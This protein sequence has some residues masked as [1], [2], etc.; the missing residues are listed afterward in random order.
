MLDYGLFCYLDVEKSGSTFIRRFLRKHVA[1]PELRGAKHRAAPFFSRRARNKLFF[2]SCRDPLS[3]YISLY[4]FGMEGKGGLH[5]R[6]SVLP[7]MSA[8]Y[9]GTPEAFERWLR[10][11]L[12]PAS[13]AKI[14]RSFGKRQAR[15]YGLMTH[16]FLRLSFR[17]W[18]LRYRLLGS[19]EQVI[20]HYRSKRIHSA[21]VRNENLA[22]DLAE[23]VRDHLE[24]YLRDPDEALS[25]LAGEAEKVNASRKS[26]RFMSALG[27][28]ELLE[29]VSEREWFFQD[30]LGY[31]PPSAPAADFQSSR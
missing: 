19:R 31:A 17:S 20:E 11:V 3:S 16:R 23:I 22:G 9:D 4:R 25:E 24:P 2:I 7:E 13:S 6:I 28:S 10:F 21:I 8:V 27:N 1:I 29:M 18:D 14:A 5:D 26:S 15:L 30:C 12:D